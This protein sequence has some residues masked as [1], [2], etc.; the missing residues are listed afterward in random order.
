MELV[1]KDMKRRKLLT[2][3]R[4]VFL[5]AVICCLSVPFCINSAVAD[6]FISSEAPEEPSEDTETSEAA[7]EYTE[8]TESDWDKGKQLSL[9]AQYTGAC[10]KLTWP[11]MGQGVKYELARS[12][13]I[14]GR[15]K[16]LVI[17]KKCSYKD[18][19]IKE[20]KLY[21]YKVR[22]INEGKQG[23][24]SEPVTAAFPLKAVK[25]VKIIR[26]ASTAL[27]IKW[28]MNP[29]AKYY[30]VYQRKGQK[31]KY[32]LIATTKNSFYISRKL[33][34]DT[35]YSYK[36]KACT[37]R[38]A[39]NT[40]SPYSKTVSK[41]TRKYQR[42]TVFAGDSLMT[43]IKLFG[44]VDKIHI[45]GSKK[46]VAYK[47][48]GTLTFQ[49]KSVFGGKTG[50]EKVIDYH[51]Y[52]LYIMLGMNEIE[53]QKPDYMVKHY[54]E[55]IEELQDRS[56]DTDIVIL[57]ISPVS[58]TVLQKRKGF[59]RIPDYNR[60]I[61]KLA[62]ELGLEYFDYTEDYKNPQGTLNDYN[63]GD[64]IHWSKKGYDHFAGLLEKLDKRLDGLEQ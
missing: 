2:I 13:T 12:D 48:L 22:P 4:R 5:L 30:K 55:L 17:Q 46:V 60:G 43:G 56:P 33:K 58:R 44:S 52:R 3:C 21:Y 26:Y 64:G 41:A 47:G 23:S 28:R 20:G 63:G 14:D 34:K 40:D 9:Q 45:G 32:K 11:E 29:E 61:K 53:W 50:L 19:E 15:Y 42:V 35:L 37:G 6:G 16:S 57:A 54:R 49:T 8:T 39:S 24:W 38:K 10:M 7:S 36:V 25:N 31:G 1:S 62:E 18:K 59:K 27:K 51:P